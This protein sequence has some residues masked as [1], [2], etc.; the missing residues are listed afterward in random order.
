[1]TSKIKY[2]YDLMKYVKDMCTANQKKKH[3]QEK[4]ERPK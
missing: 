1:M 2:S 4:F 3:C